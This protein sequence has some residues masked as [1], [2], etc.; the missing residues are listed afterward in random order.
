M[1]P[2][3]DNS[4][5]PVPS[6]LP[7]SPLPCPHDNPSHNYP[8]NTPKTGNWVGGEAV[9]LAIPHARAA[10][11]ARAGYAPLHLPPTDASSSAHARVHHRGLTRQHGNL[12]FTRV[13]Q[14]GHEV[15]AYQPEAA[16]QIFRRATLGLD[17][18]TGTVST[19]G[20]GGDDGDGDDYATEGPRDVWHVKGV[21]PAVPRPRCY[22]LAPMTCTP[23]VWARVLEEAVTVKDWFVVEDGENDHDDDAG[24]E[25]G[26][27]V[28]DREEIQDVLDEL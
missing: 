13:F 17:V 5:R 7:R 24:T 15:P 23:E 3:E 12:S 6:L 14:A 1:K 22:L 10:S 21:P 19:G 18:A 4:R 2:V 8:P 11:F 25:Q 16:Y 26:E 28:L 27:A 9:S 20:G